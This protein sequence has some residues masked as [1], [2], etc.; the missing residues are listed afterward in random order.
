VLYE[1]T[2]DWDI[3]R[4]KLE[5]RRNNAVH[6][7]FKLSGYG[8]VKGFAISV[9]APYKVGLAF[10]A[11]VGDEE[12]PSEVK[13]LL[14]VQDSKLQQFISAYI[15]NRYQSYGDK[16][17]EQLNVTEWDKPIIAK[18]LTSLPFQ[19]GTWQLVENLL[20]KDY[21]TLYWKVVNAMPY[22]DKGNMYYAID[23]LLIHKRPLSAV[24]CLDSLLHDKEDLDINCAVKALLMAVTTEEPSKTM[25]SYSITNIIKHLQERKDVSDDDQFKIEWAY[26][27]LLNRLS[28]GKTTPKYLEGRLSSDPEFFCEVLRLIFRSKH[29][30]KESEGSEDNKNIATNAYR[31]L[32]DWKTP[33]GLQS[34]SK[35]NAENFTNWLDTVIELCTNSGH[36]EVALSQIGNV[37]IHVP[38]DENGLWI[39][40]SV[41]EA[42]NRRNLDRLRVGYSNG[43]YNSRGVH[44]VDPTGK[45]EKDL[46][47][48]YRR[49]SE[50]IDA[51]GF[52]RFAATLRAIAENYDREAER[53]IS[54]HQ[55]KNDL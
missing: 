34:G 25:D 12:E 26:L 33:P 39:H 22:F 36:L 19:M 37:L 49:Y 20:G 29:D 5:E 42:L 7:I 4:K 46:A 6:E 3:Q 52:Q 53:V 13:E 41:A 15:G 21:E 48:K 18:L 28:G 16:W 54:E 1:K 30:E 47:D 31:L 24:E 32:H 51:R 17:L 27:P 50:D 14:C 10:G 43:V 40:T 11:T 45:P 8:G 55:E 35:F 9:D 38:A 44:W 2:G 23:K